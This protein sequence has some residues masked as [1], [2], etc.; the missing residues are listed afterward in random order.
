MSSSVGA[1]K[2]KI[3]KAV[4]KEDCQF[5]LTYNSNKKRLRLPVLPEEVTLSYPDEDDKT[6][7]YGVGEVII[8]KHPGAVKIQFSSFFPEE[9]CQGS[10]KNPKA[11][12]EAREFLE[13]MMNRTAPGKFIITAGPCAVNM[14]C[15]IS[16]ECKETGGDVGTLHYTLT[17]TEYKKISVRKL[18]TAKGKKAKVASASKRTSTETK[19]SAYTV[20]SG[21]CLWNIAAKYYGSGSK[22]STIYNANKAVIEAD[23]KKHGYKSSNNGSRL[24]EGL[25]LTIP[26]IS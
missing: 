7:V 14:P 16:F 8:A 4:N 11:P 25:K 9:E 10:I 3:K 24:F 18:K 12:E 2:K 13:N 15:R 21:D 23:A 1:W 22:S 5:W 17:I 26:D 19:S 6:Y 20:K